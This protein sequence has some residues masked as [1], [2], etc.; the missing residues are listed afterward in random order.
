MPLRKITTF[1]TMCMLLAVPTVAQTTPAV[2]PAV[3]ASGTKVHGT[4]TDPDGELIPGATIVLTPAKGSG[5]TVQ[6]GS[7]GT[8]SV[9][10]APGSYTF[11][12]SMK[13]FASFSM[14][15]MKVPAVPSTTVD[16]K[17]KIGTEDQVINVDASAA[18]LSVDPD[19]NASATVITGAAL[20]ALS[21]DPDDLEA[22][23]TAL[24]GPAAG[25]NGGTIYIDGFTGG[26]LPPKASIREIRINQNPFSAQYDKPGFGRVEVFT[27]PGSDQFH[28]SASMQGNDNVFNTGSPIIASDVPQPGYHTLLANGQLSGPINKN[29]SF[30]FGFQ[31][32]NIHNNAIIDPESLYSQTA[33]PGVPCAPGTITGCSVLPF[34]GY[35]A[36]VSAPDTR[37]DISPRVD[38]A[39]GP[40]NTLTMRYRY[41]SDTANNQ[42]IGGN[43]LPDNAYSSL[44]SEQDVQISDTQ[45]VTDK[46]INEIHF[47][48]QRAISA[49]TPLNTTPQLSVSGAFLTGGDGTTGTTNDT[50]N[51][52][53]FQNYTSIALK[54]NFIRFGGRLRATADTNTTDAGSNGLFTYTSTEFT[55]VTYSPN[56]SAAIQNYAMGLASNFTYTL[57]NHP[58]VQATTIDAGLYAEDDWKIKPNLTLSYG[59]RFETQN[60]IHDKADVAPRLSVS[61]GVGHKKSGGPMVVLRSGF[62]LFYDRLLLANQLDTVQN[63]GLNQVPE[64]LA[65]VTTATTNTPVATTCNPNTQAGLNSCITSAGSTGHLT[66]QNIQPNYHSPYQMQT[67]VGVDEQPFRNATISVNYQNVRGVHQFINDNINAAADVTNTAAPITDQYLTEG[68]Y[69]QNQLITNFNYRGSAKWTLSSY[70]VVN[71]DTKSDTAGVN[72]FPTNPYNIGDDFG[73]ASFDIKNQLFLFGNFNFPHLIGVSPLVS[74]RSGTP[75][76]ITTGEDNFGYLTYNTRPVFSTPGA[77]GPEG[78]AKTFAGCGT[79]IDPGKTPN[80]PYAQ[81]PANYCTGPAGFT[82][83]MRITKGFGFG[84]KGSAVASGGGDQGPGGPPGGGRGGPGGGF[85]GGGGRGGGGGGRGGGGGGGGGFNSGKKY[86]FVIGAQI[87]N[88]FNVVDRSAPNGVLSSPSFGQLTTL[89][90]GLFTTNEAV[91]RVQLTAS[92]NF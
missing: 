13:G 78:P 22:E 34:L 82:T 20:D 66:S 26:Q 8:Y 28:G 2:A 84:K 62:G 58:T 19:N 77:V 38:L 74:A 51:H 3:S 61:Y 35:V 25:P 36:V 56:Q 70:Y 11:V 69:R 75:I 71:F 7:D 17:L 83:N 68:Y 63:N 6:S 43:Q 12:V 85:G 23:L 55:G 49:D 29:S 1:M 21:D 24:A 45:T 33:S 18:Q 5:K 81:I 54:K 65:S 52:F 14:Q 48:W 92:F 47:E 64:T 80:A 87:Q 37:Y 67:N 31:Y 27:K 59:V 10:V 42:G 60:F 41:E 79:F 86:N 9:T 39:L 16:A 73:R 88:I 32:R 15:N 40:K 44:Q 57:Y 91:R 72:S 30:T 89:S 4:I 76:N 50:Q 53:E 46:I 90:G